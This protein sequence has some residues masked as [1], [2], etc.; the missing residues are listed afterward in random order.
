MKSEIVYRQGEVKD[1]YRIAQLI[2][3]SSPG[4]INYLYADLLTDITPLQFCAQILCTDP[5]Y[6]VS[7]A[8]VADKGGRVVGVAMSFPSS[9][10]VLNESLKEKISDEKYRFLSQYFELRNNDAFLLDA[11][12]VIKQFRKNGIGERLLCCTAKK[13]QNAGYALL[14]AIV[15]NTSETLVKWYENRGFKSELETKFT[16]HD[17]NENINAAH[18]MT[19]SIS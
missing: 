8:I 19:L 3:E 6:N 5:V 18:Y 13:A 16:W 7:N 17:T 11:I 1:S 14:G 15:V 4:V 9:Q 10:H 12:C 2:D